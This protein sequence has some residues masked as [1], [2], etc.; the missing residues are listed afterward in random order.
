MHLYLQL[1]R[2]VADLFDDL[3][4]GHGLISL[5]EVLSQESLVSCQKHAKLG[6]ICMHVG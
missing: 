4:D 5:L 6:C 3:R 2:M 1:H